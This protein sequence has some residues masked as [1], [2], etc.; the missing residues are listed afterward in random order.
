MQVSERLNSL[1][2]VEK[3]RPQDLNDLVSHQDII[4][5]IKRFMDQQKLPHLLFYGP[6]GTGELDW[7][8]NDFK[9]MITI[10]ISRI[11]ADG[12]KNVDN[13]GL[14]SASLW[15]KL[16]KYDSGIECI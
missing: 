2:W 1:P 12:R 13:I 9:F 3:F 10:H 8:G 16:Q 5:T 15:S 14:C 6:A 11:I 7:V 4:S